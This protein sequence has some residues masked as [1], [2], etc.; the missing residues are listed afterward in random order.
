M[1]EEKGKAKTREFVKH[2]EFLSQRAT[3]RI[4]MGFRGEETEKVFLK[5]IIADALELIENNEWGV[6]LEN[7]IT[8]LNEV[9]FKIDNRAVQLA[10]RSIE[11]CGLNYDEWNFIEEMTK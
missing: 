1:F 7:L 9:N 8:N 6:A 10:K 5:E 4:V 2:V 3:D 11:A